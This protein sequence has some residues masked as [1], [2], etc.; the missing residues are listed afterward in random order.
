[1]TRH[2]AADIFLSTAF[3]LK[4]KYPSS[5]LGFGANRRVAD[6]N[7]SQDFQKTKTKVKQKL[8]DRIPPPVFF[9]TNKLN[10][11]NDSEKSANLQNQMS[12]YGVTDVWVLVTHP[13]N[14]FSPYEELKPLQT[15]LNKIKKGDGTDSIDSENKT[16]SPHHSEP[17]VAMV[18]LFGISTQEMR[19]N[20]GERMSTKTFSVGN[21]AIG[22]SVDSHESE[23]D[24]DD[25]TTKKPSSKTMKT[26]QKSLDPLERLHYMGDR[27][28]Q[29]M[30]KNAKQ[31]RT[32]I[33]DDF[34]NRT[35]RGG[36]KVMNNFGKTLERMHRTGSNLYQFIT[37][38][39][40]DN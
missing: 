20:T 1:M 16:V 27:L 31:V 36:E 30:K 11:K 3:G 23:N 9:V 34:F 6:V 33:E 25:A 13:F 28:I 38:R 39:K 17:F 40:G 4:D 14:I 7:N 22:V 32:E 18:N 2:Q 35:I 8:P 10:Q 19:N 21:I 15:D 29:S 12:F 37:G 24:V 26:S 5:E